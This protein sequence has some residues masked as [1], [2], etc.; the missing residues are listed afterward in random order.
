ML[1]IV[2]VQIHQMFV[3][4]I[5]LKSFLD[6]LF[7]FFSL[8][9]ICS[10]RIIK[11]KKKMKIYYYKSCQGLRGAAVREMKTL[12]PSSAAL[13]LLIVSMWRLFYSLWIYV[14]SMGTCRVIDWLIWATKHRGRIQ[15]ESSSAWGIGNHG[16]IRENNIHSLSI[17]KQWECSVGLFSV[18]HLQIQ[19]S[20]TFSS[21]FYH[22]LL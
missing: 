5:L 22:F 7:N 11:K 3:E 9:S 1:F 17:C 20:S 2:P 18:H 19:S 6:T 10:S 4:S 14:L 21:L 16:W 15:L 8:S 13:L 12:D